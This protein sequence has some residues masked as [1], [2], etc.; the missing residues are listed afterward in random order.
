MSALPGGDE[1]ADDRG[2]EVEGIVR[3]RI[4]RGYLPS[5]ASGL[6]CGSSTP[7]SQNNEEDEADP[8]V[9]GMA[10]RCDPKSLPAGLCSPMRIRKSE[11]QA[12]DNSGR[13]PYRDTLGKVGGSE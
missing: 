13:N 9:N 10:A 2:A 6:S 7:M 8:I 4:K 1:V 5:H 3:T 12:T 11:V